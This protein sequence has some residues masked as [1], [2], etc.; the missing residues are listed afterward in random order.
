MRRLVLAAAAC[1]LWLLA[2]LPVAA[3]DLTIVS[4]VVVPRPYL[5]GPKSATLT[6]WVTPRKVR[7]S[8]GFRDW[9]YDVATGTRTD[10]DN[11]MKVYWQG[12]EA[13]RNELLELML[14]MKVDVAGWPKLTPQEQ[15]EMRREMSKAK[16][17]LEELAKA[18]AKADEELAKRQAL[19]D[20]VQKPLPPNL[21]GY[22]PTVERGTGDKIVAGYH[23]EHYR[24]AVMRIVGDGSVKTEVEHDL[25]LEPEKLE[26]DLWLAPKLEPPVPYEVL[27]LAPFLPGTHLAKGFPLASVARSPSGSLKVSV[28]AVV[29]KKGPIDASVFVMPSG[30]TQ[31]DLP[32]DVV[33]SYSSDLR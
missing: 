6:L 26:H 7:Q 13:E 16:E 30:Y 18:K 28:V 1:G 25:W 9:I 15:D 33:A 31:V 5:I 29:V 23:S 12:T 32:I 19:R 17:V 20:S 22:A 21:V 10:I 14:G 24:V 3:D 2:V 27:K 4:E 11:Q 8:D